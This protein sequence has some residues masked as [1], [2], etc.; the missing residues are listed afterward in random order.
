MGRKRTAGRSEA[1]A[2]LRKWWPMLLAVLAVPAIAMI[3]RCTSGPSII[4]ITDVVEVDGGELLVVGTSGRDT[5]TYRTGRLMRVAADGSVVIHVDTDGPFDLVG[6]AGDVLW[7]RSRDHGVHARRLSDLMLLDATYGKT[8]AVP[9]LK[10]NGSPLGLSGDA[11]VLQG[12]DGFPWTMTPDGVVERQAKDFQYAH[13]R[14]ADVLGPADAELPSG[15][16]SGNPQELRQALEKHMTQPVAVPCIRRRGL[17]AFEGPEG[18]L[19]THRPEGLRTALAR[20]TPDGEVTWSV[21]V[22]D[23]VAGQPF[24]EDDGAVTFAWVG[25]LKGGLHA[26]VQSRAFK[27]TSEG[28]DYEI[29]EHRLVQIDPGSGTAQ[30]LFAIVPGE[31]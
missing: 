13:R 21:D 2:L 16:V 12:A 29:V 19:V 20:V 4:P 3:V 28:D 7:V 8:D 6:I 10:A 30:G 23:L 31:G 27:R 9:T 18:R 1:K 15:C 22:G 17:L 25:R 14:T 5:D 24:E 11:A 26:L